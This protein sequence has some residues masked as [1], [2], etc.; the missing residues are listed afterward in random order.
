V[1]SFLFRYST[2]FQWVID[3]VRWMVTTGGNIAE[4]AFL[5]ATVYVTTN[6]VAHLL[7][8]WVLPDQV[9]STLNQVSTMAFSVLPELIIASAM[10]ITFD[11]WKLVWRTPKRVDAW[12]WAC[13][14]T[15]PTFVFLVMTILTI[16]TFVN[17]EAVNATPPQATGD[18]LVTRCLAGWGYGMVQ[19]LFVSIGK[20]GYVEAMDDLHA[21]IHA[22]DEKLTESTQ[23]ISTLQHDIT[24]LREQ[25]QEQERALFEAQMALATRRMTRTPSQMHLTPK[26]EQMAKHTAHTTIKL[27]E[28][29]SHLSPITEVNNDASSSVHNSHLSPNTEV[30]IGEQESY[31]SPDTQVN[32]SVLD[33][34]QES[35]LSPNTQANKNA[36]SSVQE[37]HLSPNTEAFPSVH[38]SELSP[39]TT[40]HL[41]VLVNHQSSPLPANKSV[42]KRSA[43]TS[44]AAKKIQRILRRNPNTGPTELAAKTGVSRGYA[45]QVKSQF[46]KALTS[47]QSA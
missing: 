26:R 24:T 33:S 45:S 14:Y 28:Q 42:R 36:H 19:I 9:I 39:N 10:K 29:D 12:I 11:H 46:L 20:Q 32:K 41:S 21:Q 30:N 1:I 37:S 31:Q 44:E 4:S 22:R 23:M 5:L 3:L 8:T 40:N 13:S 7:V 17:F 18:M 25:R 34:E 15:I 27:D 16:S 2:S 47:E 38:Q 43:D 35:D 6:T